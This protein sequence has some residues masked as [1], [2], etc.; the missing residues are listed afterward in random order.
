LLTPGALN[1]EWIRDGG[2]LA[3]GDCALLLYTQRTSMESQDLVTGP[4]D[5]R[6]MHPLQQDIPAAVPGLIDAAVAAFDADRDAS[7]R[8]LVRASAILRVKQEVGKGA[9]NARRSESRGGLLAWQLNRLVDYIEMNLAEKIAAVDLARLINVSVGTL[10]RAF[11]I[12]VGLTPLRYVARRRVELACTMM[13]TTREPLAQVAA[14]CGLCD[15]AHLYRLF[16]RETGMSPS[17][18]RR[19]FDCSQAITAAPQSLTS[20]GN[21][22]P[23]AQ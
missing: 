16:R 23:S 19:T 13:K 3:K 5:N 18:W 14:A 12:S 20:A 15:Q 10:F 6:H 7:R 9:E 21:A 4:S 1:V 17:D 11:K 22:A 8:C 2:K